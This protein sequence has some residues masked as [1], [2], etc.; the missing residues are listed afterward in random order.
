ML[1]P[2][3][4]RL[5]ATLS[6]VFAFGILVCGSPVPNDNCSAVLGV[7]PIGCIVGNQMIST[8]TELNGC[9]DK[10]YNRFGMLAVHCPQAASDMTNDPDVL[11]K[12]GTS[13]AG[14]VEDMIKC[15]ENAV[16]KMNALPKA[17]PGYFKGKVLGILVLWKKILTGV[18]EFAESQRR[19]ARAGASDDNGPIDQT[20]VELMDLTK[21]LSSGQEE[22]LE[23]L[24]NTG[25]MILEGSEQIVAMLKETLKKLQEV[26]AES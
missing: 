9:L 26:P 13:T 23:D 4:T 22:L 25:Q 16:A 6:V 12:N 5:I 3:A 19:G 8:M 1:F 2:R 24:N 18:S 11:Q 7:V 14:T 20:I 17:N 21:S 10:P 15:F